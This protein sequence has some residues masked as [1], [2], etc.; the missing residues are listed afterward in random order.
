MRHLRI[1]LF[2]RQNSASRVKALLLPDHYKFCP[3]CGNEGIDRFQV[4]GVRCPACDFTLYFNP[5]SSA[6]AFIFDE[7]D[8]LLVIE[9]ARDPAKGKFGIPGG[10]IDL[11]EDA[12][13]ALRREV[14]EEMNLTL[15]RFEFLGSF[16]NEYAYKNV[17]YP[18]LDLYFYGF[19]SDFSTL[20]LEESEVSGHQFVDIHEVPL[21]RWAFKSLRDAVTRIKASSR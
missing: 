3:R 6:A 20:S 4:N 5:T 19:V 7:N 9:R 11:G 21:E 15:D 1:A 10:F 12:E 2:G 8:R 16:P 18:V 17:I 14:K 13:T